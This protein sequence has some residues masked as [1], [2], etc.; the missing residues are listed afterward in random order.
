MKFNFFESL[1]FPPSENQ[2]N[3]ELWYTPNS[4]KFEDA[5][6]KI[7]QWE[8]EPHTSETTKTKKNTKC[9]LRKSLAWDSAF[10]TSAGIPFIW[11]LAIFNFFFSFWMLIV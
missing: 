10:F 1:F 2:E 9:N 8:Q 6:S 3:G 5:A 7:E 4:K 11:A